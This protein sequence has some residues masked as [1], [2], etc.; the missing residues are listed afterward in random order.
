MWEALSMYKCD[1]PNPIV[2]QHGGGTWKQIQP[3]FVIP[4]RIQLSLYHLA[5]Y[6]RTPDDGQPDRSQRKGNSDQVFLWRRTMFRLQPKEPMQVSKFVG[7]SD[8]TNHVRRKKICSEELM[9]MVS[10]TQLYYI[11]RKPL[12]LRQQHSHS[13]NLGKCNS[14]T[15]SSWLFLV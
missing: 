9:E 15:V 4:T 7:F 3:S 8:T 2:M 11:M 10:L 12:F 6:H 5:D 14:S 13:T 1:S